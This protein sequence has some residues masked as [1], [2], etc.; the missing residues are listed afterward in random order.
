M[1]P[2]TC[3]SQ[4]GKLSPTGEDGIKLSS[5]TPTELLQPDGV[6]KGMGLSKMGRGEGQYHNLNAYDRLISLA[7]EGKV[8][9]DREECWALID[10]GAMMS[11]ISSAHAKKLG[12]KI[13]TLHRFL[14]I[15][16]T[17]ADRSHT[18]DMWKYN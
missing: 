4:P 14:D 12:L 6:I 17:G 11:T 16:G 7:N 2:P 9:L 13:N 18:V 10:S 8:M 1:P 5:G 3:P 15:E